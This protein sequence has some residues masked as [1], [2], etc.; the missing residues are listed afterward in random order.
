M[1]WETSAQHKSVWEYFTHGLR[2]KNYVKVY[3]SK[4][5]KKLNVDEDEQK[6]RL[7]AVIDCLA[8]RQRAHERYRIMRVDMTP[9]K[10]IVIGMN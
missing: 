10:D 8:F 3:T 5:L 7:D 4:I 9:Q 1:H 2:E 6:R